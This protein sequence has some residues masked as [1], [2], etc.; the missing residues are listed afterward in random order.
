MHKDNS[1]MVNVLVRAVFVEINKFSQ[2]K[3]GAKGIDSKALK[4]LEFNCRPLIYSISPT[5]D[6]KKINE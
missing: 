2:F 1:S 5:N 4:G 6:A 3:C